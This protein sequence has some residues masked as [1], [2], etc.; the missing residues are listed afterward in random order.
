M[1]PSTLVNGWLNAILNLLDKYFLIPQKTP[2]EGAT[3][4]L[5]NQNISVKT[6]E[7]GFFKMATSGCFDAHFKISKTYYKPFEI[8]FGSSSNSNSYQVKSESIFGN[9]ES[10][11]YS[12]PNDKNSSV[13]TGTWIRQNSE[14]FFASSSGIIYYL[15]TLKIV[16]EE[17][18]DIEN[19]YRKRGNLKPQ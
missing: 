19:E 11:I 1:V 16:S 13:V 12:N 5:I 9:Y 7:N 18:K 14:S 3:V 6:D 15:D 4:L 2:V 10:P 17:I 8:T